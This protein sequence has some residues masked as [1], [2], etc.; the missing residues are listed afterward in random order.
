MKRR[1]AL[2]PLVS[3]LV[4][5]GAA[6]AHQIWLEQTPKAANLYFGEFGENL[7]ET[8]P[9]LLDK[10]VKPTAT[11]SSAKG[12]QVLTLNK[13]ANAF[14]LSAPAG[15]NE[16]ITVEETNY[17]GFEKKT[18]ETVVRSIWTPAARL[19]TSDAAQA[20][21]LTLDLV[22]N[23]KPG[24]F[25]VYYKGQALPKAKVGII[26]QSGWAKEATSDEQGIVKFNLPWQGTYVLEV[27]HTDK[28]AG[29]RDGKPY[30][31]ASFVTT[32]SLAQTK[33]IKAVAAGPAATPNK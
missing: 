25:K 5:A 7:R 1:L 26:V 13:Q 11:L 12:D 29:E 18:G 20:P 6:H 19:V 23:G 31:V 30:D 16:T 27:H 9:G 15:K 24:E 33:G 3:A 10:F 32:L 14:T 28:T 21:K 17:P 8:S 2:L 4:F 22:P